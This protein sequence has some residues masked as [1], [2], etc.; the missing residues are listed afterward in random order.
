MLLNSYISTECRYEA[1]KSVKTDENWYGIGLELAR[2]TLNSLRLIKLSLKLMKIDT[3]IDYYQLEI[4]MISYKWNKFE[5]K[6]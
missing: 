4:I 1:R 2:L 3:M 6:W 5:M